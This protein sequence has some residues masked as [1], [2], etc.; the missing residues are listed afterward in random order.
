MGWVITSNHK[1]CDTIVPVGMSCQASFCSSQD[2]H[3]GKLD[4]DFA[5]LVVLVETSSIMKTSK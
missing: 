1:I 2:S 5:S 3:I 4:D